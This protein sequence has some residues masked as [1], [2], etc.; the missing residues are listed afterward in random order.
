M[1]G[2]SGAIGSHAEEEYRKLNATEDR[3]LHRVFYHLV[4]IDDQSVPTRRRARRSDITQDDPEAETLVESLIRNRL[5]VIGKDQM[6]EVAHEALLRSW[7]RLADWIAEN[8]HHIQTLQDVQEAAFLWV[9]QGKADRLLWDYEELLPVYDAIDALHIE[10]D[11]TVR[12]F[13][14]PQTDR[15]LEDFKTSPEYRQ[16][17]ILD[18]W[19]EIGR[20][21]APALVNALVYVKSDA[22]L[23]AIDAALWE[24]PEAAKDALIATLADPDHNMRIAV[25]QAISRLGVADAIDGLLNNISG[26][27]RGNNF[28]EIEALCSI[29]RNATPAQQAQILP[30]LISVLQERTNRYLDERCAAAQAVGKLGVRNPQV[31]QAL[32]QG[33]KD[34]NWEVR[35]DCALALGQLRAA[36]AWDALNEKTHAPGESYHTR[37]AVLIALGRLRNSKAMTTLINAAV[38]PNEDIRCA[39][40]QALG[41]LR[42]DGALSMLMYRLRDDSMRVREA[43]AQALAKFVH[44]HAVR[45]LVDALQ[46]EK[47]FTVRVAIINALCVYADRTDVPP[48]LRDA[49]NDDTP[50]V[51]AAAAA[52]LGIMHMQKGQTI[53][54]LLRVLEEKKLDPDVRSAVIRALATLKTPQALPALLK[55]LSNNRRW[56]TRFEAALALAQIGEKSVLPD[57]NAILEGKDR[58]MVFAAAVALAGLGDQGEM[59]RQQLY[60]GLRD[61]RI[62]VRCLAC[63]AFGKL[64]E[65]K[66]LPQLMEALRGRDDA[67]RLAA[68]G[69]IA[70]LMPL[71]APTLEKLQVLHTHPFIEVREAVTVALQR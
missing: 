13:V 33:L 61:P 20:G 38:D 8:G 10:L 28:A 7:K 25:A 5:L 46:S 2:V 69:A 4:N 18:R 67:L 60:Q 42:S 63:E 40:V 62:E 66:A 21:A 64:K 59:V 49:L 37:R 56:Q 47:A 30:V 71:D 48:A 39:A 29:S 58:D 65:V 24:M 26:D 15:L 35:R 16:L 27:R 68:A 32:L 31:V 14:R 1:G 50:T 11:T 57:L 22:V 23:D 52:A 41:D 51:R 17:S 55:E 9:E 70:A 53:P 36:E 44:A 45:P 43:T 54:A 12:E 6:V 34:K 19:R 3:V